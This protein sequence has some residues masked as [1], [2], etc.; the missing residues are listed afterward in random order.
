MND[1][2]IVKEFPSGEN[3]VLRCD[4]VDEDHN[5]DYWY[6]PDSKN[7]IGPTQSD[8]NKYKYEYEVLSGNLTIRVS[9]V[10]LNKLSYFP[11][12]VYPNTY[13]NFCWF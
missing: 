8:F 7:I 9:L 10:V 4:S 1:G 13:S 11:V 12:T 3:A 2:M 6:H 5:F